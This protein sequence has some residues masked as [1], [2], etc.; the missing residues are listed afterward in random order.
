MEFARGTGK[1]SDAR[2]TQAPKVTVFIQTYNHL[3][4]IA[5]AIESAVRQRTTFPFEILIADDCSTDGTRDIVVDYASRY[6]GLIR[7]LLPPRNIGTYEF[8]DIGLNECRGDYIALLEGDDYWTD[9]EKI[10]LQ[11]DLMDRAGDAYICG[12]R[13]QV[14]K[15][16]DAL[17]YKTM[18][19][20]TSEELARY[21]ARELFEGKWWFRTCTKMYP[22]HIIQSIPSRFKRDWASGLWLIARTNFGKVCFLDRVVGVYREH[23]GGVFSSRTAEHR[24]MT[25]AETLLRVAPLFSGAD[26]RHLTRMLEESVS[27]LVHASPAQLRAGEIGRFEPLRYAARAAMLTPGSGTSWRQVWAGLRAALAGSDAGIW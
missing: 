4:F 12:A 18:P 8:G 1:V 21:G 10:Q 6:P 3:P 14:L 24:A 5:Q 2:S 9:D 20:N 11:A 15:E 19:P 17:P 26:R 25:D 7:T 22:R 13:A 23:A 16:G 27:K